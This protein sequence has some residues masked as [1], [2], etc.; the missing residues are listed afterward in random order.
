LFAKR[1]LD[2]GG[3][4]YAIAMTRRLVYAQNPAK[5]FMNGSNGKYNIRYVGFESLADAGR[6]LEYVI[7]SQKGPPRR[8]IVEIPGAAFSG[9]NRV[10]FQESA[11]ICYEKLRREIEMDAGSLTFVLTIGEI[12][13]LRPRRRSAGKK[14]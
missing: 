4:L 8:A 12:E 10:T 2:L 11:A 6:R 7:T 3:A 1:V 13:A 9:P 14:A 5:V